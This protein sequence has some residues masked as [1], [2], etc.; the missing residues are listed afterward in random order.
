MEAIEFLKLIMKAVAKDT[1]SNF[2]KEVV[3]KILDLAMKLLQKIFSLAT[4][5]GQKV[6]RL[7]LEG[8]FL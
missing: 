3:T 1:G 4:R 2:S 7:A 8:V 5:L 6:I